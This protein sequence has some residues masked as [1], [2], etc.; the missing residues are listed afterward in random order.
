[1]RDKWINVGY[2]ADELKPHAEPMENFN[3][4][5]RIGEKGAP[6]TIHL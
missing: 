5:N 2:D 6:V 1:M 3:D 4:T